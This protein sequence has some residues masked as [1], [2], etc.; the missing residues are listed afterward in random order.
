VTTPAFAAHFGPRSLQDVRVDLPSAA[1]I[2]PF[3][4]SLTAQP[5]GGAGRGDWLASCFDL[6]SQRKSALKA[7]ARGAIS[8]CVARRGAR[9]SL[10]AIMGRI[11]RDV[12]RQTGS[13][14][15]CGSKG[16]DCSS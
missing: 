14:V 16:G 15:E 7:A 13:T 12:R 9:S 1:S 6:P 8:P 2:G 4:A 5:A 3:R 11:Q 10:P